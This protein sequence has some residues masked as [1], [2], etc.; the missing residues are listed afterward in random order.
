MYNQIT[1]AAFQE[2]TK[3]FKATKATENSA[4]MLTKVDAG[5]ALVKVDKDSGSTLNEIV[6]KDKD[7]MYEVDDIAGYM[8]FKDK[9]NNISAYNL[10]K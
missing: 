4:F 2:M 5:V 1:D 7:P 10:N 8:Y 6:I 3:R 9:S